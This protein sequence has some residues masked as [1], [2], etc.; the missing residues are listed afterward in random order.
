MPPEGVPAMVKTWLERY[1][2][3]GH[4]AEG[5]VHTLTYDASCCHVQGSCEWVACNDT[6][7]ATLVGGAVASSGESAPAGGAAAWLNGACGTAH[8]ALQRERG[9]T[10][11]LPDARHCRRQSHRRR[12]F[13]LLAQAAADEPR[14]QLVT[15]SL[16][17]FLG[18]RIAHEACFLAENYRCGRHTGEPQSSRSSLWR[19]G[20]AGCATLRVRSSCGGESSCHRLR[21]SLHK[22]VASRYSV[23]N[24][25]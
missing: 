5:G 22:A 8:V 6:V 4:V 13:G 11:S 23:G 24:D 19:G 7:F 1:K 14:D 2:R 20:S 16:R 3:W 10:P 21:G 17:W 9:S 25:F 12:S 15:H 18:H